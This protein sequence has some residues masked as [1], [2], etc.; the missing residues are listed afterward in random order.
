MVDTS[1]NNANY[2]TVSGAYPID[3]GKCTTL[4]GEFQNSASPWGTFDQSGNLYEWN[5]ALVTTSSRGVR[6][7]SFNTGYYYDVLLASFRT[8]NS[9]LL[10][11]NVDT[12]FRVASVFE[13]LLGDANKNGTVNV[14]DLT[15]LLNN[16]NKAGMVWTNGDFTGDGTVNVADL[17]ILLNNYNRTSGASLV[18]GTAVPEPGSL[19]MLAGIALTALLYW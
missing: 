12:G 10:Y 4:V 2:Y 19:V 3:S 15:N 14:A 18:A 7:G 5:E 16:Y 1:G 9:D 17:T 11:E 6:G 8:Y 13:F